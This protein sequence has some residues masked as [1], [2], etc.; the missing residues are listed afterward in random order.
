MSNERVREQLQSALALIDND[1]AKRQIW[2]VFKTMKRPEVRVETVRVKD[3]AR[4]HELSQEVNRLHDK[5]QSALFQTEQLRLALERQTVDRGKAE[6]EQAVESVLVALGAAVT[7]MASSD[8][9]KADEITRRAVIACVF[10]SVDTLPSVHRAICGE[11]GILPTVRERWN[12]TVG[13]KHAAAVGRDYG[14]V[15]A[16]YT[17]VSG[18]LDYLIARVEGG[19]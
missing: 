18:Y 19:E 17:T 12:S 16:C 6:W 14:L 11:P 8:L 7:V 15:C 3:D 13:L 2:D 1:E 5:L 10:K 9:T 4:E